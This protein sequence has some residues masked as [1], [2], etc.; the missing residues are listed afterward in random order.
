MTALINLRGLLGIALALALSVVANGCRAQSAELALSVALKQAMNDMR[1]DNRC[2]ERKDR[3]SLA[4]LGLSDTSARLR[5]GERNRLN[6]LMRVALDGTGVLFSEANAENL[7]P[8]A[9]LSQTLQI[10]AEELD[11]RLEQMKAEF[12]LLARVTRP[13]PNVVDLRITLY[14]RQ[15]EGQGGCDRTIIQL[16]DLTTE[17]V[18]TKPSVEGDYFTFRGA[19]ETGLTRSRE[20]LQSADRLGWSLQTHFSAGCL[21]ENWARDEAPGAYFDVR[22]RANWAQLGSSPADYWPGLYEDPGE[23]API[24]EMTLGPS[25]HG[26]PGVSMTFKVVQSGQTLEQ[27][28]MDVVVRSGLLRGCKEKAHSFSDVAESADTA[29]DTQLRPGSDHVPPPPLLVMRTDRITLEVGEDIRFAVEA[30]VPCRLSIVNVDTR[31]RSCM[32]LP[33]PGLPDAVLSPGEPYVFPPKGRI[34]GAEPGIESFIAMCNADAQALAQIQ[35]G[36]TTID[37]VDRGAARDAFERAVLEGLGMSEPGSMLVVQDTVQNKGSSPLLRAELKIEI[38][39]PTLPLGLSAV[40]GSYAA[41]P[42]K[43][44]L[45]LAETASVQDA[46]DVASRWRA[47]SAS[48]QDAAR[49]YQAQGGTYSVVAT[50]LAQSQADLILDRLRQKTRIPAGSDCTDGRLFTAEIR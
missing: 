34:Y 11:Q 40:P 2:L 14:G 1:F 8:L 10:D 48:D 23:D 18:V 25:V 20:I 49:I 42:G 7:G 3:Y 19:I 36:R 32:I 33:L 6:R 43:C 9:E 50:V 17:K 41:P 27:M 16:I 24:L 15:V 45:R 13:E 31:G 26:P 12:T 47:E 21:L 46:L 5:S 30:P 22:N 38:R 29:D 44:Y 39:T 4:F 35:A 28:R 37:C